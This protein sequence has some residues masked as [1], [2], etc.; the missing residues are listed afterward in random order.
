MCLSYLATSEKA[1]ILSVMGNSERP[2][3]PTPIVELIDKNSLETRSHVVVG[4]SPEAK[5]ESS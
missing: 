4:A 2:L 5:M 1:L 3:F